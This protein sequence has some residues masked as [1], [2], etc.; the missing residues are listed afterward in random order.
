MP[1]LL[2]CRIAFEPVLPPDTD[3]ILS[4]MHPGSVIKVNA[5]YDEPFWREDGLSGQ[6]LDPTAVLSFGIKVMPFDE[7]KE[8]IDGIR[9]AIDPPGTETDPPDGVEATLETRTLVLGGARSG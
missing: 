7:Q 2:A 4:R 8:L 6:W 5:V 1:P 3:A 9:A